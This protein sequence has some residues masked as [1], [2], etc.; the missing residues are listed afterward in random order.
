MVVDQT[1]EPGLEVAVAA[2]L[3][4]E[5]TLEVD[6]P[7]RIRARA[8]VAGTALVRPGGPGRTQVVEQLLDPAVANPRDL[9]PTQLGRNA[10]GV[11]VRVQAH[12]DHHLLEPRGVS[13]HGRARTAALGDERGEAAAV[14]RALPAPEARPTALGQRQ[15]RGHSILTG[16]AHQPGACAKDREIPA[17]LG[18]SRRP[19]AAG[20]QKSEMR[21]LL[22]RVSKPTPLRVA[23]L[24]QVAIEL[25][26]GR[27]ASDDVS[28]TRGNFI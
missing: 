12:R 26:H 8:L 20:R 19:A 11:P 4:E 14:V 23:P 24:L 22:V 28:E 1:H 13:E 6:V 18:R 17:R 25:I 16:D 10:L 27:Q 9:P 21:A 15:R 7:E 3:D 2:Q 5:G